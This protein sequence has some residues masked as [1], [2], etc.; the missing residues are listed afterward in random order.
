MRV[1]RVFD[2]TDYAKGG[3]VENDTRDAA[4]I[5]AAMNPDEMVSMI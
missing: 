2:P 1:P 3:V 4:F 5:Q